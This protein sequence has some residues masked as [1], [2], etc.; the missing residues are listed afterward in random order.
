MGEQLTPQKDNRVVYA[1]KILQ[2]D[3]LVP[4]NISYMLKNLILYENVFEQ[5]LMCVSEQL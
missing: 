5:T 1:T 3:L 2:E 4:S